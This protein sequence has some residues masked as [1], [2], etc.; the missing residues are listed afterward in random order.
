MSS[1]Y[2]CVCETCAMRLACKVYSSVRL[3]KQSKYVIKSSMWNKENFERVFANVLHWMLQKLRCTFD[4]HI[5]RKQLVMNAF[6][7]S[8]KMTIFL[9]KLIRRHTKTSEWNRS[10]RKRLESSTTRI[11]D[12]LDY[13]QPLWMNT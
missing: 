8:W 10:H 4:I 2:L 5:H 12:G 6:C 3:Q 1:L 9:L 11:Q 7:W 13:S